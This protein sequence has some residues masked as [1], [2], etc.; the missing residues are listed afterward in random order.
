MAMTDSSSTDALSLW[1][2][3]SIPEVEA[4]ASL[5]D[6][7]CGAVSADE[8]GLHAGDIIILAQKIVSKS[9]N[10]FI[11]LDDVKPNPQALDVSCVVRKD[12]RLVELILQESQEIVRQVPNILIVRHRLG[13]V[14][15]NAGIDQ[16]NVP[17]ATNQVLL[18]PEDPDK[19]ARD[20]RAKISQVMGVDVAVVISDSFGR[21]WR[22]G[23]VGVCIGCAGLASLID[24]RTQLD[25]EGRPLEMT[26]L[27]VGDEIAA[28]AS[29]L[30]GQAAEGCPVVVMRGYRFLEET[31]TA[32]SLLRSQ[33]EDLFR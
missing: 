5:F 33:D 18:L 15:A 7:V 9:E 16:S 27:A 10:R 1:A 14:V 20:L 23:V 8:R 13:F 22:K 4:G 19:S 25:R 21:P 24:M 32:Q 2:L 26:E 6:I 12:P 30:M 29:L 3:D 11:A 17:N 28:A 31:G